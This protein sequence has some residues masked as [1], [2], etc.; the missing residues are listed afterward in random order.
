[1]PTPV[2]LLSVAG[3]AGDR[4]KRLLHARGYDV[5]VETELA[6]ATRAAA[7]HRLV[8]VE[9]ADAARVVAL[10]RRVRKQ[11]GNEVPIL[12]VAHGHDVEERVALLEAGADDVLAQPLDERE[13]EAL[14]EALLMRTAPAQARPDDVQPSA[15]AAS[16]AARGRVFVFAATKGGA[17]STTLAVNTA[18]V[19][20]MR[21][22]LD[23]AIVDMDLYHG[24]VAVHLDVRGDLSTAQLAVY[25]QPDRPELL[26]AAAARHAN[27][28]AVYFAPH[29]P[30]EGSAVTPAQV[31]RLI[32][33]IRSQHGIVV[34]DAG[35]VMDARALALLEM[36]DQVILSVTPEIPALRTLHGLLEVLA[37]TGTVA[38]RTHFVLNQVYPKAMLTAEQ[39]EENL[40]VKFA[41]EI[42]YHQ[43]LYVKAV[44]EGQP[45]V[46]ANWRSAPSVQ[47]RHLADMLMGDESGE[48]AAGGRQS[49]VNRLRRGR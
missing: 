24:Q 46:L 4:I 28:L 40:V 1:M 37:D 21:P 36:A 30:D 25:E 29:R 48:P 31:R 32:D 27:G 19:L 3:S 2:L 7:T 35:T 8:V 10:T 11:L 13:L 38:D 14:V 41:L 9:A 5:T 6:G 22:G 33:D 23:V 43:Q 16:R 12:A 49:L 20:A 26:A 18:L 44:N 42:P 34:V 15:H 39:I 17:G 45:V 47:M